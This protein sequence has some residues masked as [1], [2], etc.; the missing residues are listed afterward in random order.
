MS[1]RRCTGGASGRMSVS[2]AVSAVG[3]I[4]LWPAAAHAFTVT[5]SPTSAP[6]GGFVAVKLVEADGVETVDVQL[7]GQTLVTV[8]AD[9]GGLADTCVQIPRT[10]ALTGTRTLRFVGDDG[11][12]AS[13]QITIAADAVGAADTCRVTAAQPT[14]TPTTSPAPTP[15][16]SPST[17]AP[18]A[19]ATPS[20]RAAV[21]ATSTTPATKAGAAGTSNR[22]A[23][24]LAK[25]GANLAL[26]A[27]VGALVLSA[28]ALL[29]LLRREQ[30]RRSQP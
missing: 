11:T 27:G 5:T 30:L 4:L 7:E 14:P 28:G 29:R 9:R 24:S 1:R 12:E 6:P 20:T 3:L 22:A 2:V 13:A 19:T 26:V 16:A 21:T 25:T 23:G 17:S 8:R 15:T 10:D 18:T